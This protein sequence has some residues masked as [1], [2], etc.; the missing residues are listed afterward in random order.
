MDR[1]Y[2]VDSSSN[3]GFR[4]FDIPVL[5]LPAIA[6]KFTYCPRRRKLTCLASKL[7]EGRI[8]IKIAGMGNVIILRERGFRAGAKQKH[9]GSI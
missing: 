7:L 8:V 1:A 3:R 4:T 5:Q 9:S 6:V 2:E